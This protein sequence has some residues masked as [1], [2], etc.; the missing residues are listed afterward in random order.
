MAKLIVKKDGVSL[1]EYKLDRQ[2]VTIGRRADNPVCLDDQTVSSE[3]AAIS[4]LETP[5]SITD[6]GSTN[7]TLINGVRIGKQ[8]L[9]HGDV[10]RI[11]Q[12]ELTFV[13]EQRQD[14][15][16]TVVLMPGAP[17]A[18]AGR[19]RVIEGAKAGTVLPLDRDRITLGT[20][21]QQV[22]VVLREAAGFRLLP[23]TRGLTPRINHHAV[24]APGLLLND[25]DEIEIGGNR[26]RYE[27]GEP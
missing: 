16:A 12:H 2:R 17:G 7:G 3:H 4:A 10:I 11:G 21:G 13:D 26:I 22:A 20:P 23:I 25:G 27:A 18:V 9:R 6:L 19:L 8:A 1:R 15:S 24:P 14:H 5:P